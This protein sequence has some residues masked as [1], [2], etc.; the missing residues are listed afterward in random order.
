MDFSVFLSKAYEMTAA[1]AAAGNTAHAPLG[2][3]MLDGKI[4]KVSAGDKRNFDFAS[5][6]QSFI[7]AAVAE[8]GEGVRN[9]VEKIV[10]PSADDHSKPLS[11]RTI[12]TV[13]KYLQG[14]AETV[15][16]LADILNR[17]AAVDVVAV[18]A[19][20]ISGIMAGVDPNLAD[21]Y[22]SALDGLQGVAQAK[23]DVFLRMTGAEVADGMRTKGSMG[24]RCVQEAI[25]AQLDLADKLTELAGKL[26][27]GADAV[28]SMRDR[29]LARATE[30]N[31]VACELA[32]ISERLEK[33]EAVDELSAQ[34]LN[35]TAAKL[36]PEKALSMHG[37]A[38]A[39]AAFEKKIA[40]LMCRV[41]AIKA[42]AANGTGVNFSEAKKIIA[43]IDLAKSALNAAAK[44]GIASDG[45]VWKPNA[46][47][48]EAVEKVLDETAADIHSLTDG[49]VSKALGCITR[50]YTFDYSKLKL[51]NMAGMSQE[52]R[53]FFARYTDEL[54]A[55]NRMAQAYAGLRSA[56]EK[57]SAN[58]T[59]G[60]LKAVMTAVGEVDSCRYDNWDNIRKCLTLMSH[61]NT[62]FGRIDNAGS[63]P[64]KLVD[65]LGKLP[66]GA[67]DEISAIA[68]ELLPNRFGTVIAL[69][70]TLDRMVAR[71]TFVMSAAGTDSPSKAVESDRLLELALK[72]SLPMATVVGAKAWGATDDM[73]DIGITDANLVNCERLGAGQGNE[74]YKCTYR[75]PD[76]TEKSYVFK[77]EREGEV[78][79]KRLQ[80][81]KCGY[82]DMESVVHLNA[83]SRKAAIL[84]G[85]PNIIVDTKV[86]CVHGTFGLFMELA[87][88]ASLDDICNKDSSLS[89]GRADGKYGKMSRM[90]VAGKLDVNRVRHGGLD[91]VKFR[92]LAGNFMRAG[93][94]LEWNDW[95]TGQTD[96]HFG[97]YL[98]EFGDDQSVSLK[99]IDNDMAFP[100][101]RLGMMKFRASD[102]Q[103]DALLTRLKR[104]GFIDEATLNSMKAKY[105]NHEAFQFNGDGSVVID[106]SKV[107]ELTEVM[108]EAFG[109]QVVVKPTAISRRMYDR[110]MILAEDPEIL[111]Q[112][113]APHLSKS[114]ID[115]MILRLNEMVEHARELKNKGRVLEDKDWQDYNI[116]DSLAIEQSARK[117]TGSDGKRY[118]AHFYDRGIFIRDFFATYGRP[119]P[120]MQGV[121]NG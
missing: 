33:N 54:E 75:L 76:G 27:S 79:M 71:C 20:D 41:E 74:V 47:F 84:L 108:K 24:M 87:P 111:R 81:T 57:L 82:D 77:G 119:L 8:F 94:D 60:N 90:A 121:A 30:I 117:Y 32:D 34:K 22:E 68:E 106:L 18:S 43:E 42:G 3:G 17:A 102:D 46:K 55:A 50:Q 116:Q 2:V 21:E 72:G 23:F 52:C 96:R 10:N 93:S 35:E 105:G 66:N 62:F 4:M 65:T 104:N 28:E 7:D 67:L 40:P 48:L 36:L 19:D 16:R 59:K 37:N 88:G 99:A 98:V 83:A 14:S 109:F 95:L 91:P 70:D 112:S 101:W 64:K 31:C 44:D 115:A 107:R 56:M 69:R 1:N 120:K 39:I 85:T 45:G 15:K 97:N 11:A 51:F 49:Y 100:D 38:D 114:A 113:M 110:L 61:L 118:S 89:T 9:D 13:D 29:A 25:K 78:A 63:A 26:S 73:V 86:G 80:G 53:D 103:L 12:L 5:A 58:P 92:K 6:R